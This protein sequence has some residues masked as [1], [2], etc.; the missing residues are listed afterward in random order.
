MRSF[1]VL[2]GVLLVLAG[3]GFAALFA[4]NSGSSTLVASGGVYAE[5][6]GAPYDTGLCG[7]QPTNYSFVGLPFADTNGV[8]YNGNG[9]IVGGNSST[10]FTVSYQYGSSD[11]S[12]E[13]LS[14]PHIANFQS[15]ACPA[16]VGA[17][18]LVLSGAQATGTFTGQA[19]TW[20]FLNATVN[21]VRATVNIPLTSGA[22]AEEFIAAGAGVGGLVVLFLGFYLKD[23]L[24]RPT[25]RLSQTKRT[26]Y[27]L[28]QSKLAVLGLVIVLFFVL[29]AITSPIL[30]P[31]SPAIGACAV[32]GCNGDYKTLPEI[33]AYNGFSYSSF[34]S[35]AS[36][37]A[38]N[39]Q[40]CVFPSAP[41]QYGGPGPGEPAPT[42]DCVPFTGGNNPYATDFNYIA[43]TWTLYP[44]NPG[45]VPLGSLPING[46]GYVDIYQS[47]I[48]ATPWDLSIS[49]AIVGAGSIIGLLLGTL[50]GYM[51]G[52]IDEIIMRLTDIFLSIP[53]LLL[54]LIIMLT[55]ATSSKL[56]DNVFTRMGFLIGAFVIT[57]WPTYTRII[58]GQVLVTREQKYVEAARASGARSGH[59]LRKHI[60][61][62]SIFPMLVQ[63]S[64]DV[65]TIPITLGAIA[66]LGFSYY[67]FPSSTTPFPEWGYLSAYEVS[68]SS[69]SGT[70][71]FA[72]L[73]SGIPFPWWE[74][75]FPGLTL[76][77]FCIAVNFFS[78]GMRDA[79]DPRLRR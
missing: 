67:I 50:A 17:P 58:R 41:E 51:G 45:P 61:P 24:H 59:I 47:E 39:D 28:F 66:F 79:L 16:G 2:I 29:V 1:I 35:G 19:G 43:P 37:S 71:L 77:L 48:R 9:A 54:V 70:N 65:G 55:I 73:R 10:T 63:F 60:I 14:C 76:F 52:L 42:G 25:P 5:A 46:E 53:G 31:Y 4:T 49:I 78:D 75:V 15:P 23:P 40:Q 56:P 12:L 72:A 44:F 36:Y 33:F 34:F 11:S 32:P 8:V 30:A 57:W 38:G 13:V 64:L 21:P 7:C 3:I 26:L 62:N 18:L 6:S 22:Q 20:Y 68:L 74:I 69:A 27:F